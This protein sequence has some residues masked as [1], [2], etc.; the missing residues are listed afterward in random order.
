ML[1]KT[2]M[3][4]SPFVVLKKTKHFLNHLRMEVNKSFFK[5]LAYMYYCPFPNLGTLIGGGEVK[6]VVVKK[7]RVILQF[8]QAIFALH[9]AI[10]HFLMIHGPTLRCLFFSFVALVIQMELNTMKFEV[11]EFNSCF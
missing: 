9:K 2:S 4:L 3:S 8:F 5:N 11:F 6:Q 10:F 7:L 1:Q